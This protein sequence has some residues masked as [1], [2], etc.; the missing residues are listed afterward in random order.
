M[1]WDGMGGNGSD[2]AARLSWLFTVLY[3]VVLVTDCMR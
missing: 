1:G 2:F 3:V